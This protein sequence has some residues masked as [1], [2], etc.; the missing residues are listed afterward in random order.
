MFS[1]S[2]MFV[3]FKWPCH[4]EWLLSHLKQFRRCIYLI[5]SILPFFLPR[6]YDMMKTLL[7]GLLNL[8]SIR[9]SRSMLFK[10]ATPSENG[11]SCHANICGS[12][13]PD[14]TAHPRSLIRAFTA[15]YQNN[16]YYRMYDW[17]AKARM[18][19]PVSRMIWIYAFSSFDSAHIQYGYQRIG[20]YSVNR[21]K[22]FVS[23]GYKRVVIICVLAFRRHAT[24]WRHWKLA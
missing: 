5:Y 11:S 23:Y 18:S 22:R 7:T 16:G 15:S 4:P 3:A 19:L 20:N 14:Q 9:L 12:E 1:L 24:S 8:S 21:Y 6:H 2:L 17:R 10:W 13:G